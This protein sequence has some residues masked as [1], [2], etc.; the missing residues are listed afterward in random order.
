MLAKYLTMLLTLLH[1]T[2]EVNLRLT[3]FQSTL[4]IL[5]VIASR[6]LLVIYTTAILYIVYYFNT[7]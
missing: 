3:Q 7:V 4:Q 5:F 1:R 2:A 6:S